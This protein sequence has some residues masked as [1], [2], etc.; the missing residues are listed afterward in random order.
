MKQL[1]FAPLCIATWIGGATLAPISAQAQVAP[2]V[3][4]SFPK[5]LQKQKRDAREALIDSLQMVRVQ[6][7]RG[8]LGS[9]NSEFRR[10]RYENGARETEIDHAFEVGK[11][12]VTFAQWDACVADGGCAGHRPKDGGWGRGNRPVINISFDDAQRYLQWLNKETGRK[13]RLL[14]EAEWEYVARGGLSAPFGHG[15]DITARVANF[16][17]KA[18]YGTE[19]TGAYY[20]KTQ[21]VGQYPANAFGLHDMHGNVYEWVEDC[22]NVDHTA[23]SGRADARRDGDCD[24]RVMKG[25]SWVTHGYQ[26]RAAARVRY[27][28]DYRYDDYGFR[29]A[30]TLD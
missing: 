15:H 8:H 20:R 6:P 10:A 7:G 3:V 1:A 27:V 9:P 2:E 21:P 24:Y 18:P 19:E 16:D 13:Y 23:A 4:D 17:G 22:W 5:R 14:S 29:L 11:F 25:G 30:R 12:E 28:T 26:M